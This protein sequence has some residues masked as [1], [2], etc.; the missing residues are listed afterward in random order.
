MRMI[1]MV[2]RDK[3]EQNFGKTGVVYDENGDIHIRNI[4]S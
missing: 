2:L 4:Y 3:I 1:E